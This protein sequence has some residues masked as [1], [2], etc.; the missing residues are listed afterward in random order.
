MSSSSILPSN[1]S[2]F[3][4][5]MRH[6]L[7]GTGADAF[8]ISSSTA[9]S[10]ESLLSL[11]RDLLDKSGRTNIASGTHL[12]ALSSPLSCMPPINFASRHNSNKP[13]EV[14]PTT[15]TSVIRHGH[16]IAAATED[17]RSGI[18]PSTSRWAAAAARAAST[19]ESLPSH[20]LVSTLLSGAPI[21]RSNPASLNESVRHSFDSDTKLP[22]S[23][24]TGN[25]HGSVSQS[26]ASRSFNI[27]TF[28][29]GHTNAQQIENAS[30]LPMGSLHC[31]TDALEGA[32]QPSRFIVRART[33][34]MK[35]VIPPSLP[36]HVTSPSPTLNTH[37]TVEGERSGDFKPWVQNSTGI[38]PA[39]ARISIPLAGG[40]TYTGQPT[41]ASSNNSPGPGQHVTLLPNPSANYLHT[42][43]STSSS[44]QT[45]SPHRLMG[46]FTSHVEKMPLS[47]IKAIP[48]SG[49]EE[50]RHVSSMQRQR[51]PSP[52]PPELRTSTW[53][54]IAPVS[55][56]TPP[57]KPVLASHQ[58]AVGLVTAPAVPN[59]R[60][61]VGH[62]LHTREFVD[63][64]P[65][66]KF[67]PAVS[68]SHCTSASAAAVPE[69]AS[70]LSH[71][72][73]SIALTN[74]LISSKPGSHSSALTAHSIPA[75]KSKSDAEVRGPKSPL[76]LLAT[77]VEQASIVTT[78][79]LPRHTGMTPVSRG[80]IEVSA[81][82]NS[83]L[84]ESR[85]T[86]PHHR[87]SLLR[88]TTNESDNLVPSHSRSLSRFGAARAA[89]GS[90]LQLHESEGGHTSIATS[91]AEAARMLELA[92]RLTALI[93]ADGSSLHE[94]S[95]AVSRPASLPP[96]L[97]T[98]TEKAVDPS[99][100]QLA[101]QIEGI[102]SHAPKNGGELTDS[103]LAEL[104]LTTLATD[105]P[106]LAH[107]ANTHVIGTSPRQNPARPSTSRHSQFVSP[108]LTRP[109]WDDG[110]PVKASS[111]L[112]KVPKRVIPT[113]PTSKPPVPRAH[114]IIG[115][116]LVK[117]SVSVTPSM[118]R[119]VTSA[120]VQH[121]QHSPESLLAA[122]RLLADAIAASI[123]DS[124]AARSG[125]AIRDIAHNPSSLMAD[126]KLLSPQQLQPT[127]VPP[128]SSAQ[129]VAPRLQ[130]GDANHTP[131]LESFNAVSRLMARVSGLG[132]H[133]VHGGP[134]L[135]QAPRRTAP[136][137]AAQAPSLREWA[138]AHS[139][140]RTR[141]P[142]GFLPAGSTRPLSS[143]PRQPRQLRLTT[144]T[145]N[146]HASGAGV[147]TSNASQFGRVSPSSAVFDGDESGLLTPVN[148]L[149]S[150]VQTV[151]AV[152]NS[153]TL[154]SPVR[155]ARRVE[156]MQIF[157]GNS[158]GDGEIM[159]TPL[160]SQVAS[161]TVSPVLVT[162]PSDTSERIAPVATAASESQT[163]LSA[164]P[165]PT[166]SKIASLDLV[167]DED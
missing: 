104:V 25:L 20:R 128:A 26:S 138:A 116:P 64:L 107:A 95:E 124:V 71:L 88:A 41:S 140:T 160:R 44:R 59:L 96:S 157:N 87:P 45:K 163:R 24:T 165:N 126:D 136:A 68:Q 29:T 122:A 164:A 139:P 78:T 46:D 84:R 109:P 57:S 161:S 130:W 134:P 94:I 167:F 69:A 83:S 8:R 82:T 123:A 11:T 19:R 76:A 132:R 99:S 53:G 28:G 85:D 155:E 120:K 66:K 18:I 75:A 166:P 80:P 97:S 106:N 5:Q 1:E 2:V 22:S 150:S 74:E 113:R 23:P 42:A 111:A 98:K 149:A 114:S 112:R 47:V 38:S 118:D 73:D 7:A 101:R 81:V 33:T 6:L 100:E 60:Q 77:A 39:A 90:R 13:P 154:A 52:T 58:R 65:A 14:L 50:F 31:D 55:L 67:S 110:S 51:A 153:P 35:F 49:A 156:S 117:R 34:Q 158:S 93:G 30:N 70:L 159:I 12:E 27:A 102:L 89:A 129:P 92:Q 142:Q 16:S 144:P 115:T 79:D 40:T 54:D 121:E 127:A 133:L 131:L 152:R 91:R 148:V 43:A 151:E 146:G 103:A 56:T 162:L 63:A 15:P 10:D 61:D 143:P 36:G 137:A 48:T 145:R 135:Q 17:K 141:R 21:P 9:T 62:G 32:A 105:G 147:A 37:K 4:P 86:S 3:V 108:L 125:S 119:D 72:L